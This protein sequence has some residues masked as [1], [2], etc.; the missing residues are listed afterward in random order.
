MVSA[1]HLT[2]VTYS[3]YLEP[4]HERLLYPDPFWEV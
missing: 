2:N 4:R 3:V 1:P